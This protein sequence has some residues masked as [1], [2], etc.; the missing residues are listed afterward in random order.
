MSEFLVRTISQLPTTNV[1]LIVSMLGMVWYR[2]RYGG[3]KTP[4]ESRKLTVVAEDDFPPIEPHNKFSW[5][6]TEPLQLRPYKPKYNLTMALENLEPSELIPVDKEYRDRISERQ[7]VLKE[8]YDIALGIHSKHGSEKELV[9]SGTDTPLSHDAIC[10]LYE[11]VMGIYLPNRYPTMFTLIEAKYESGKAFMLQNKVTGEVLPASVSRGRPLV[12]A[13][14]TLARTIDE[15][16]LILLPAEGEEKPTKRSEEGLRD[17]RKGKGGEPFTA[18]S[19]N[20]GDTK[21]VLQAYVTCFPSGFN[22]RE[23]LGKQLTTIHDPVP[24]YKEKLEK[25]MDRYFEK[26]EVGKFMKRVNWTVTTGAELFSAFGDIHVS[27]NEELRPLSLEELD[28]DDTFLR[29][30]RQTLYRLPKSGAIVFS[31]HTYRYPIRQIKEEGSGEELAA[32]IDGIEAGNI[33]QMGKYKRVPVWGK[34]VKEYLRS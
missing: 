2:A 12:K 10:E 5:E 19:K 28:L 31:I 11:F 24:G 30:E 6:A 16:M 18:P 32:A 26:L 9:H 17:R 27:K 21:Y 25:S 8:H 20:N 3:A 22:T 34:A 4:G 15:D 13:L 33:P 23:K 7:K 1:I 14:E 29:C